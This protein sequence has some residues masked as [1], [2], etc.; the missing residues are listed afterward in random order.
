MDLPAHVTV[1]VGPFEP[2]LLG[3]PVVVRCRRCSMSVRTVVEP[4]VP[5]DGRA[6]L[7]SFVERHLHAPPKPLT[8]DERE[9]VRVRAI[10]RRG[11]LRCGY[12]AA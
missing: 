10:H 7:T 12:G 8:A 3:S 9:R 1:S 5:H 4:H 2:G 11:A 6:W